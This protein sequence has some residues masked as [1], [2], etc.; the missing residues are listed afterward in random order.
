LRTNSAQSN[1]KWSRRS[2]RRQPDFPEKQSAL[3]NPHFKGM[4]AMRVLYADLKVPECNRSKGSVRSSRNKPI[5]TSE[6][7]RALPLHEITLFVNGAPNKQRFQETLVLVVFLA[8]GRLPLLQ[9]LGYPDFV[10]KHRET[11]SQ[12]TLSQPKTEGSLNSVP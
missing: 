7:K 12:A 9:M 5:T 3:R 1:L 11:Q 2:H 4:L 6:S 8:D 10:T